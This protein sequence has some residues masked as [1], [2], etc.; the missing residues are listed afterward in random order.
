MKGNFMAKKKT[1]KTEV[2]I[3]AELAKDTDCVVLDDEKPVKYYVDTGNLATNYICSGKFIHG[4]VAGGRITEIF[5]PESSSKSLFGTNILFGCQKLGG[6]AIILDCENTMNADFA[7]NASHLDTKKVLIAKP[8]S[9][10][11]A[12]K[13][14]HV[15]IEK[16]REHD[17]ERPIVVVYDSITVS[18]CERELR[19]VK[20]PENYTD[21]EFKKIVGGKEQPG[22]RAKICSREFRKLT[23]LLEKNDAT[24][25][26]INQTRDKIGVMF[27]DNQTTG[28]GGRALPFYAT[29]RLATRAS[30]QIVKKVE[31]AAKLEIPIGVNISLSNK[32]NKAYKPFLKTT[33]LNLFFDKGINPLTGLLS[34]LV[35][36]ERIKPT[37]SGNFEVNPE[38]AGSLGATKFKSSLERNDVPL[39]MLLD[40]PA[41]VGAEDKAEVEKYMSAFSPAIEQSSADDV[42]ENEVVGGPVDMDELEFDFEE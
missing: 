9:L 8:Q 35:I 32:K 2:D 30:K 39:Q 22:E 42:V 27:G 41:V 10:E 19:E 23:P 11:T 6:Y 26:V 4:G 13:K 15:V 40:N 3:F 31:K 34:V 16:I 33:G 20:L 5:G 38:Y 7:K 36:A 14:I 18:P 29:C 17:K 1:R 21:A 28:G 37:G 25:L 24:L 12:F